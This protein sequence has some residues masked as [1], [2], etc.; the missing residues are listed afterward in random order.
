MCAVRGVGTQPALLLLLVEYSQSST[1]ARPAVRRPAGRRRRGA[2]ASRSPAPPGSSSYMCVS[3][4]SRVVFSV[5]PRLDHHGHLHPEL[6]L[7]RHVR[8]RDDRVVLH[9][10]HPVG[11]LKSEVGQERREEDLH[12][13]TAGQQEAEHRGKK[14]EV[15]VI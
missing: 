13:S 11:G 4:R 1:P 5:F 8:L 7:P 15:L 2:R 14:N 12:L 10:L 9:D 3:S 6:P